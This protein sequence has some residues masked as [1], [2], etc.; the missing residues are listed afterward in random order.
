ME[1]KIS[2]NIKTLSDTASEEETQIL[3]P[4]LMEMIRELLLTP[5][6]EGISDD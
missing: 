6:V 1:L 2:S 3:I 5:S 4:L